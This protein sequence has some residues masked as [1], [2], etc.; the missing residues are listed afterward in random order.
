[1]KTMKAR[2]LNSVLMALFALTCL[3]SHSD[4]GEPEVP[5][6]MFGELLGGEGTCIDWETKGSDHISTHRGGKAGDVLE[7]ITPGGAYFDNDAIVRD[8]D[9]V[10]L[11]LR[12]TV[13]QRMPVIHF[14]SSGAKKVRQ[15]YWLLED[16]DGDGEIDPPLSRITASTG[17]GGDVENFV[18]IRISQAPPTDLDNPNKYY[19]NPTG[20]MK[21]CIAIG[22]FNK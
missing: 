14:T 16:L 18:T 4:A 7:F 13:W 6:R 20:S 2:I 3:V 9:N 11:D 8:G 5:C 15:I 10:I 19:L 17:P 22:L 1:M 21:L 12:S